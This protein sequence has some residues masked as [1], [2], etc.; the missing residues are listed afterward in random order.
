MH[1]LHSELHRLDVPQ[2]VIF[3]QVYKC[4]HGLAPQYLAELCAPVADI[5]DRRYLHSA[6]RRL[7]NYPR[8]NFSNCGQHAF[9]HASPY[10]WKFLPYKLRNLV[11]ISSFK[12]A[13]KH[14]S[15]VR[16]RIQCIRDN[17]VV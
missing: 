11:S 16:I 4:L 8:Y 17:F 10:Y 9:S 3:K 2:H 12:R 5:P 7:L 6:S 15:S 13:L 14:S 1:I